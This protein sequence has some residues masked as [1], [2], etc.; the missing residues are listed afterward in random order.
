MERLDGSEQIAQAEAYFK[1]QGFRRLFEGL[2]EKYVSLAHLGGSIR[3]KRLTKEE[4]ESLEGFLQINVVENSTVSVSVSQIRKALN[5]TRY[6]AY[7]LEE[8]IPLVLKEPL[9]T[10]KEER[11]N[12]EQERQDF[13]D[14]ISALFRATAAGSWFDRAWVDDSPLRALVIRDYNTNR[15]WLTVN[16]PLILQ[17]VNRLPALGG[18]H[19]RLPVF[20]A[21]VT[22]NPHYFDEGKRS[23]TYLLQAIRDLFEDCC[24]REENSL[25]EGRYFSG[26]G[27]EARAE[28]LYTGGIIKD[29]LS[30]WVL[31]CGIRGYLSDEAVHQG[32]AEY[33]H[34]GEPQILTLQNLSFLQA[35]AIAGK[36]VFVVE[37]PSVFS[38]LVGKNKE[39]F[40][41]ICSNGQ[42]R[43]SV[44][45][46]LDL[47]VEND[48]TICYSGDF[49][50]EGLS[51]AQK[52]VSR[53][54]SR[55]K[56]CGYTEEI[57][58]KAMSAET[59]SS[60]RLKQLEKL[61][62]QRL[63][64]LGKLLQE[65]RRPGYQENVM[66]FLLGE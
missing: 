7:S 28:L 48:I 62:D 17:A 16:L 66:D 61:Q 55:L 54:G 5:N 1:K 60:R 35:A 43:L 47:L 53:Y 65:Y 58:H 18:Q 30:N 52:L 63:I 14:Q 11:A 19:L 13:F 3:L 24:L 2:Q 27:V 12:Q 37:N 15:E 59:I 40:A 20:A 49:D 34:R 10:K 51:I 36:E 23:L 64:A 29:D 46:L 26:G 44:L 8:I 22:G 9:L 4:A 21:E 31:C 57:Y 6:A 33:C 50:P 56:L 41:C 25:S 32:M 42:L 38:W 39:N 45:I